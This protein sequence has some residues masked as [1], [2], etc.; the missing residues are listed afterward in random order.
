MGYDWTGPN[1]DQKACGS[2]YMVAT[3]TM[4]ESRIKIWYGE[5]RELS[6]QFPL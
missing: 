2:C 5:E 3:N 4:L 6:T 1:R